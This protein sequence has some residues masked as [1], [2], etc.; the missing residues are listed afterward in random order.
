MKKIALLFIIITIATSTWAQS[1][2]TVK[3][4]TKDGKTVQ[5][6]Y[7]HGAIE[8]YIETVKYSLVDEL[9]AKVNQLQTESK[10][11]RSKLDAANKR[12]KEL[13]NKAGMTNSAEISQLQAEIDSK[14]AQINSLNE[15]IQQLQ[16]QLDTLSS[17]NRVNELK[18]KQ[19]QDEIVEK[20]RQLATRNQAPKTHAV[21]AGQYI[22][23]EADLGRASL[24]N[25]IDEGWNQE[26][27]RNFQFALYYG[28]A[29][30][31]NAIPLS[32]EAGLGIHKIG[33]AVFSEPHTYVKDAT[34][35]D[36]CA[37][38][39]QY[40]LG[41]SQETFSA[42]YF[43]IPLRVCLGQPLKNNVSVYAKLGLTPSLKIG[44]AFEGSGKYTLKAYYESWH[45]TLED[46][47]ELGLV[48]DQERYDAASAPTVK[49]FV[50]WGDVALGVYIPFG[51]SPVQMT[52]GVNIL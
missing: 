31:T 52:A 44:S 6:D 33:M 41:K 45:V 42:T 51:S 47:E 30:L 35:I 25:S 26:R 24:G 17:T 49:G 9:K 39:A 10:D 2:S 34:D 27:G 36:G 32:L 16:S 21:G 29:R 18:I 22:A 19:L 37:F 38:Q 15:E 40:T 8:D 43:T 50:L 12:V 3:G 11:L 20:D 48:S 28:T 1:L 4:K 23:L 7:Y 13:E 14:E 5:V 46:I